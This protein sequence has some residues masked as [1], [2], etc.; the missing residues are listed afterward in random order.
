M[1]NAFNLYHCDLCGA[2]FEAA[3]PEGQEPILCARCALDTNQHDDEE[4]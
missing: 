2:Q 3:L 1:P 4:V